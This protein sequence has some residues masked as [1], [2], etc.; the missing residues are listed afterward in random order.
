SSRLD[1]VTAHEAAS[2]S[3]AISLVASTK[4]AALLPFY[5]LNFLPSSVTSR[6]LIATAPTIDL[7]LGYHKA[8][9]SPLLKRFLSRI[10]DLIAHVSKKSGE[11]G[12]FPPA[13]G[14]PRLA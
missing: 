5:A 7:V 2:M 4:G 13:V 11:L 10:D 8:N 6:R 9:T 12:G 14:G 1:I 3:M